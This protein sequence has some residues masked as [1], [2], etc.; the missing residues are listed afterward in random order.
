VRHFP[1]AGIARCAFATAAATPLIGFD[2]T[3]GQQRT[4]GLETL[5]G[6]D[7][8]ECVEPAELG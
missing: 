2:D 1:R 7:E 3:A 4:V 5:A 6:H 8:S